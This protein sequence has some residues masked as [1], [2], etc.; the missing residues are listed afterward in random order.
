M[1]IASPA[2]SGAESRSL[3]DFIAFYIVEAPD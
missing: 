2:G 3:K 1:L